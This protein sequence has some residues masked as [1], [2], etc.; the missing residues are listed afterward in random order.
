M[1]YCLF[2]T[3]NLSS[4]P[5]TAIPHIHYLQ[6]PTPSFP[7]QTAVVS[8]P[9]NPIN[10]LPA[11]RNEAVAHPAPSL[12]NMKITFK[13]RQMLAPGGKLQLPRP[14]SLL[15]LHYSTTLRV[16]SAHR[17]LE[18]KVFH[19]DHQSN[20]IDPATG[21]VRHRGRANRIGMRFPVLEAS[22]S[23]AAT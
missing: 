18:G 23:P 16:L 21:Q 19:T 22:L 20:Y 3:C 10:P 14:P 4:K 17:T 8:P 5:S 9:H 11:S 12:P 15:P 13:V 2:S 6:P 7:P 1:T